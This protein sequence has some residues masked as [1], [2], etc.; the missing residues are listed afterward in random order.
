VEADGLDLEVDTC[1]HPVIVYDNFAYALFNHHV[2]L[3]DYSDTVIEKLAPVYGSPINLRWIT[4]GNRVNSTAR[5]SSHYVPL[6]LP[7]RRM[8][9]K[10]TGRMSIIDYVC[11]GSAESICSPWLRLRRTAQRN[12]RFQVKP[13]QVQAQCRFLDRYTYCICILELIAYYMCLIRRLGVLVFTPILSALVYLRAVRIEVPYRMA[14]IRF[15]LSRSESEIIS[16]VLL[17]MDRL[18]NG[19]LTDQLDGG[20]HQ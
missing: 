14:M 16:V 20:V 9:L 13:P 6:C 5:R 17:W 11:R 10:N 3:P 19:K 4:T 2:C 8:K 7:G 15:C 1:A 18:S 12:V